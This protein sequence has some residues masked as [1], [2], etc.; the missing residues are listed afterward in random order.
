MDMRT[1]QARP[2]GFRRE[3]R[4][5]CPRRPGT[6]ALVVQPARRGRRA[7]FRGGGPAV[8]GASEGPWQAAGIL[9]V[10]A[11]MAFA[12][13]VHA[14]VVMVAWR[15]DRMGAPGNGRPPTQ[16][17]P[18]R[19]GANA[20]SDNHLR[21]NMA[22]RQRTVTAPS[23]SMATA[24]SGPSDPQPVSTPMRCSPTWTRASGVGP[25]TTRTLPGGS[26]RVP[27]WSLLGPGWP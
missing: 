16:A 23:S 26:C 11:A 20:I 1:D 18:A 7:D 24:E 8:A 21:T 6:P 13:W 10:T 15:K 12:F 2:R 3:D 17:G 14:Q 25:W 9:L 4:H 19:N 22:A 5:H 27:G